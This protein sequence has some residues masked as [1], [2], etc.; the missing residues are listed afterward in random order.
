MNGK[1]VL[2][3]L[4]LSLIFTHSVMAA[5]VEPKGYASLPIKF[6]PRAATPVALVKQGNKVQARLPGGK[7]QDLGELP[8]LEGVGI[9][10]EGLLLQADFNFDGLGDVAV[11]DGVGYGGVNL[12]YRLYTWDKATGKF[13]AFKETISNPLLD[14]KTRIISTS[15]RSGPR[16]YSQ[17]YRFIKGKPYLWQEGLMV[18]SEGDLYYVKTYNSV[19]KVLK[20][21]VVEAASTPIDEKAVPATRKIAV[22]KAVLYIKADEKTKTKQYVVKGDKVTLLDYAESEEGGSGS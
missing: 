22:D 8:N 14:A 17:D 21:L 2:G 3:Y 12:F 18:G 19:G 4:L 15:Q 20:K 7:T 16:W 6:S 11:L 5:P 1:R 13:K 9:V 10:P